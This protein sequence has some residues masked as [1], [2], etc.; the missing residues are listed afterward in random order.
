MKK[1]AFL[2]VV[3]V[4]MAIQVGT[5]TRAR[6]DVVGHLTEVTGQ[7]NLMKGGKLPA[8]TAK[9]QDGVE[10]GDVVRTKS[11][12][13]ALITFMDNSTMTIAPESK[14]AI[15]AYMFEPAQEKRNAVFQLFQGLA[16]VV[17]NKVFKVQNPDFIVKTHTAV[18]GVRGTEF[19]IRLYPASSTILNFKGVLEVGNFSPEISGLSRK[20]LKIA[21]SRGT[22]HISWIN[23]VLLHAMQ[24]ATVAKDLPPATFEVTPGML[25]SFMTLFSA[26]ESRREK[27]GNESAGTQVTSASGLTG[28]SGGTESAGQGGTPDQI[29]QPSFLNSPTANTPPP[30]VLP[31]PSYSFSLALINGTFAQSLVGGGS[32]VLLTAGGPGATL[33]GYLAT[34]FGSSYLATDSSTLTA[35]SGAFPSTRFGTYFTTMTGSV[36]GNLGS[37]LSGSATMQS[38][39]VYTT[40]TVSNSYTIL[41]RIDPSGQIT[42]SYVGGSFHSLNSS[43]ISGTS[44]GEGLAYP[45]PAST[46]ETS[47]P[48]MT[49]AASD[50]STLLTAAPASAGDAIVDPPTTPGTSGFKGTAGTH[51][52]FG[53][54]R[55]FYNPEGHHGR[56]E[57]SRTTTLNTPNHVATISSTGPMAGH[58]PTGSSRPMNLGFALTSA[59]TDPDV[60]IPSARVGAVAGTRG[61]AKT[62]LTQPVTALKAK[63]PPAV[64][65]TVPHQTLPER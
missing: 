51:R 49:M 12:S 43:A 46:S 22:G 33:Q 28:G 42:Y 38:S 8:I 63:S 32:P 65:G 13:K 24:G 56:F 62:G 61:G 2:W 64:A 29:P 1:F 6:A 40:Y 14:V 10:P 35:T 4:L 53:F 36:S 44:A 9:L 11:A 45:L 21:Y 3:L 55:D 23:A 20:A 15:E 18:M 17:V 39:Y 37:T 26:L 34:I 52:R 16:Y 25:K 19:G 57:P 60:P 58:G 50:S 27:G 54:R 59:I 30:L 31:L 41:V 7:V 47:E 5:L 48:M